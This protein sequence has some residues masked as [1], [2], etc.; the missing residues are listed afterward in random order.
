MSEL[1]VL[2][3]KIIGEGN[4]LNLYALKE[5]LILLDKKIE[6]NTFNNF[7]GRKLTVTLKDTVINYPV[8]H[9]L[10]FIPNFAIITRK[11]SDT[12]NVTF[13]YNNFTNK[14]IYITTDTLVTFDVLVGRLDE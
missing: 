14:D 1:K 12:A 7:T 10:K 4:E 8:S 13:L 9:G 6:A 2:T 3:N 5:I 11:V